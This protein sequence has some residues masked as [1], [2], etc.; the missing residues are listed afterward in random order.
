MS[1]SETATTDARGAPAETRFTEWLKAGAGAN[2]NR[3]VEHP[4]TVAIGDDAMSPEAYG[5]YVIQDRHFI[6]G[7]TSVIGFTLAKAP[8]LKTQRRLA[9]FIAGEINED[10]D[11]FD[12]TFAALG[13]TMDEVAATP[14]SATTRALNDLM[15]TAARDGDYVD[16][17]VCILG[18]EWIY[19][20]WGL[21]EAKKPRP[22]RAYLAEWIDLHAV[23]DFEAFVAWLRDEMD[24]AGAAVPAARRRELADRFNRVC[25]LEAA[26]FDFAWDKHH[27]SR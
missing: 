22:R 11:F 25:E 15:L 8:E 17:L 12:R 9:R 5:P 27:P 6:D 20:T 14:P 3:A 10:A 26:F 4:F 23:P 16:G 21:R 24:R 18:A 19:L 2:W 7:F 1:M 13:I